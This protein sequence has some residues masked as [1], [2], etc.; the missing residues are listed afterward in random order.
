MGHTV[1][2]ARACVNVSAS[3]CM[4]TCISVC[5][6]IHVHADMHVCVRVHMHAGVQVCM[7]VCAGVYARMG[8]YVCKP[9]GCS[10]SRNGCRT[11]LLMPPKM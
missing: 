4:Q 8:A 7:R 9:E 10:R 11:S 2:S 6:C 1:L 5:V 3:L